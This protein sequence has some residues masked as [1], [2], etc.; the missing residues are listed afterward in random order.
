MMNRT[1]CQTNECLKE[2]GPG[3]LLEW[4]RGSPESTSSSLPS[5]PWV[6]L[7]LSTA[8]WEPASSSSSASS[9]TTSSSDSALSAAKPARRRAEFYVVCRANKFCPSQTNKGQMIRIARGE[10]E[11]SS[12]ASV[13][14]QSGYSDREASGPISMRPEA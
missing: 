6:A 3:N 14:Q 13:P 8:A 4:L 11:K 10:R 2:E 7:E 9:Q 1:S 12:P 5:L